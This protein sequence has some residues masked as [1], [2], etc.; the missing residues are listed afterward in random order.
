MFLITT[1]FLSQ[2]IGNNQKI[3]ILIDKYYDEFAQLMDIQSH[4]E[5]KKRDIIPYIKILGLKYLNYLINKYKTNDIILVMHYVAIHNSGI[6]LF[7]MPLKYQQLSLIDKKMSKIKN[8]IQIVYFKDYKLINKT[9]I[10]KMITKYH[11]SNRI[12]ESVEF[13]NIFNICSIKQHLLISTNG[14]NIF[15]IDNN[16][17]KNYIEQI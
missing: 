15:N 8:I 10:N 16:K 7:N 6:K 14:I 12:P 4:V 17:L 11:K 3:Q 9:Y 1:K 5:I 2:F 13:D